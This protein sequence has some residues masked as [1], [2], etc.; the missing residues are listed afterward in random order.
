MCNFE[1]VYHAITGTLPAV[2][3]AAGLFRW[4]CTENDAGR[5]RNVNYLVPLLVMLILLPV[6]AVLEYDPTW[7][8][9]IVVFVVF[10]LLSELIDD[11]S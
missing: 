8:E 5:T 3:I 1:H 11:L 6:R 2:L 4:M 10:P 7:A 9:F